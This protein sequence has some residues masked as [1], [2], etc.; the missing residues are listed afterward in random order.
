M[1]HYSP[2]RAFRAG[3]QSKLTHRQKGSTNVSIKTAKASLAAVFEALGGVR[4]MTEWAMKEE[5]RG[6]FYRIWSKLIPAE[7]IAESDRRIQVVILPAEPTPA[8]VVLS[9][10]V[11]EADQ[12]GSIT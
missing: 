12:T 3:L 5:N 2:T 6:E 9:P 4:G 1:D 11:D 10:P 7:G 8:P